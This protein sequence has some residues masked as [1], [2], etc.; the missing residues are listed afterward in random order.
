MMTECGGEEE[1]PEIGAPETGARELR[2][3]ELLL[4]SNTQTKLTYF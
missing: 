4:G 3:N 2:V 1:T